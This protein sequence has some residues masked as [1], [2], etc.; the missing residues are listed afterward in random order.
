[1]FVVHVVL[2]PYVDRQIIQRV[3]SLETGGTGIDESQTDAFGL[4]AI[5]RSP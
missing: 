3:R 1:M 4:D 2:F 5:F